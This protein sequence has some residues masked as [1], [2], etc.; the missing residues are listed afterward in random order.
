MRG[1]SRSLSAKASTAGLGSTPGLELERGADVDGLAVAPDVLERRHAVALDIVPD[2][3]GHR[4]AAG[5]IVGSASIEGVVVALTK[6]G[7][8]M[9]LALVGADRDAR[10][11]AVAERIADA[12]DRA[13]AAPERGIGVL[14]LGHVTGDREA[15]PADRYAEVVARRVE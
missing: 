11:Q 9:T 7:H 14:D 10:C 4:E 6:R 2:A 5:D 3:T 8:R 13:L 12:D 15:F 1:N